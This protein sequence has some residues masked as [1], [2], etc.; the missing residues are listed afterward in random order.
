MAESAR[1]IE[2]RILVRLDRIKN[3][4]VEMKRVDTQS[5]VM[6]LMMLESSYGGGSAEP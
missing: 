3:R 6:A 2:T 5:Q 4:E 1:Q